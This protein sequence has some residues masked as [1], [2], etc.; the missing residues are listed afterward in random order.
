MDVGYPVAPELA[1]AVEFSRM[2]RH[3]GSHLSGAP[4]PL[5]A[6]RPRSPENS[7]RPDTAG[8]GWVAVRLSPEPQG[9]DNGAV[10]V[11]I[12]VLDVV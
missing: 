4:P 5:G 3:R 2:P 9:F 10:A 12:F 11:R 8:R 6:R 1:A 7:L